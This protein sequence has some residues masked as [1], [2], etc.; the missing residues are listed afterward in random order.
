LTPAYGHALGL[1]LMLIVSML[2]FL[3]NAMLNPLVIV[4]LGA[5]TA[6]VATA[7]QPRPVKQRRP[8][9]AGDRTDRIVVQS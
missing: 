6:Y 4:G 8:I 7:T 5:M 9:A 2:D 3:L 1:I